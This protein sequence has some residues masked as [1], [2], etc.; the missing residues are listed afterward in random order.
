MGERIKELDH[1]KETLGYIGYPDWLM[2]EGREEVREN[3]EE[4]EKEEIAT[5][6]NKERKKFPVVIPYVKGLSEQL[7]RVYGGFGVPTYF[8]PTNRQ[9]LVRPNDPVEK[10][11]LSGR[12]TRYPVKSVRPRTWGRRNDR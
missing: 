2:E 12:C 10:R 3:T 11:K 7:R 8:K 4:E 6:G 5:S 9:L 1:I